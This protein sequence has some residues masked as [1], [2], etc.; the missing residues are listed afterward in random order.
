MI[1]EIKIGKTGAHKS[2]RLSNM[3]DV[4][5]IDEEIKRFI[6]VNNI[7]EAA[8]SFIKETINRQINEHK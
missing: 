6:Q 2:I 5:C 7:K 3:N 1:V 4:N 8:F